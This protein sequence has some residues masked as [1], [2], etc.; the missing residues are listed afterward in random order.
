[1]MTMWEEEAD[2][3]ARRLLAEYMG[4]E[5]RD[6]AWDLIRMALASPAHTA[7]IPLQ[8][9]MSWDSTGRM[10]TPGKQ[11]GNWGW[12]FQPHHLTEDIRQRL[13]YLTWLYQRRPEQQ[14]KVYGDQAVKAGG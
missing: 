7:V 9:L 10:N 5:V 1:S 3:G 14:I 4:R 12:R 11:G 6:I 13:A 8:D 2:E